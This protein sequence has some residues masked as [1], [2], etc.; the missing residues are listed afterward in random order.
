MSTQ[1]LKDKANLHMIN[2]NCKA[3][4]CL[5]PLFTSIYFYLDLLRLIFL[6]KLAIRS[7]ISTIC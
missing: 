7:S 2:K 1:L 4:I 3:S 5:D 6:Q